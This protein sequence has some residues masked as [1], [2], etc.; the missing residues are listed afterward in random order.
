MVAVKIETGE[1]L[2]KTYM[3]PEG[4]SGNAVWGSSPAIDLKRQQLYIATGI[5][6][7]TMSTVLSLS[8]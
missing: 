7:I 8:I 1:I 6:Q 4:Y 2:W 3:T 5:R